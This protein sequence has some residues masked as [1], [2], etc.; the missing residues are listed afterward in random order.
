MPVCPHCGH[1]FLTGS[2]KSELEMFCRENQKRMGSFNIKRLISQH[3]GLKRFADLP[4]EKYD[5][6]L[7]FAQA[8][9]EYLTTCWAANDQVRAAVSAYLAQCGTSDVSLARQLEGRVRR[10]ISD[11]QWASMT[12]DDAVRLVEE[13]LSGRNAY[14]VAY[15][16]SAG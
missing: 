10:V 13:Q 15:R 2:P 8:K 14:E 3:F 1:Q 4:A 9:V 16:E 12:G 6:A 11:K 7:E 5:E